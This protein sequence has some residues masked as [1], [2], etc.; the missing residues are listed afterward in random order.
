MS[1]RFANNLRLIYGLSIVVALVLSCSEKYDPEKYEITLSTQKAVKI[2]YKDPSQYIAVFGDI[3]YYTNAD[4]IKYFKTSLNWI[5]EEKKTK[6]ILAVLHTGDITQSNDNLI[7]WPHFAR[8]IRHLP[9]TIPFISII[10]DHDY[11][12]NKALIEDRNNTHFSSHVSF[13]V[14]TKRI[15]ASFEKNRMENIVVRNEIHGER[16]DFLLLEFG[17]RKEVV[18]WANEWV[19]SHPDVK[20]ILMNHEYLEQGG[21]RRVKGLKCVSRLR[22]TTYTKP[23]EL[24][25]KLIK[26][27]DNILCVLCGHVGGLYAVTREEND[28]GREVC[29]IQHNIQSPDYRYD[30]W[31]MMWK[32]PEDGDEAIASIINTKTGEKYNNLDTLFTFKYRY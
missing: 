20:Y 3:Q 2:E 7:Q 18:E 16:Y 19:S 4:C 1:H 10:G 31:L 13:P 22:N 27:N 21:G 29:Q 15:E 9:D 26:C 11:S 5:A 6:N 8:A 25:N 32:F 30:N 17:P 28:F 24:W 12:W 14:V 23:D